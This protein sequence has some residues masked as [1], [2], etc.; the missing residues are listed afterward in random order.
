[1]VETVGTKPRPKNTCAISVAVPNTDPILAH[2]E[3]LTWPHLHGASTSRRARLLLWLTG[4]FA[5]AR[6]APERPLHEPSGPAQ[7]T[8]APLHSEDTTSTTR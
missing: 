5:L 4:P 8:A 2:G 7:S 1:M 3:G 6:E